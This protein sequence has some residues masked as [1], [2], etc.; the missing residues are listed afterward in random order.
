MLLEDWLV[1][2]VGSLL[3]GLHIAGLHR[4]T[5]NTWF[6]GKGLGLFCVILGLS[7]LAA[8]LRAWRSRKWGLWPLVGAPLTLA[9]HWL[10]FVVLL[11]GYENI[12][13]LVGSLRHVLYDEAL[14]RIDLALFPQHPTLWLESFVTPRRTAWFSFFYLSLYLYPLISGGLLYLGGR[15]TEFRH[16]M[17]TFTLVGL[18]GYLGY[19]C[20]PVIGPRYYFERYY[21]VALASGQALPS[22][23]DLQAWLAAPWAAI[24]DR[25]SYDQAMGSGEARNCFP[26]LH[27]A[28]GLVVLIFAY[29]QLRWLFWIYLMPIALLIL[30]TLYLRFHYVVD[31]LAGAALAIA[32]SYAIPQLERT[33]ARR[34]ASTVPAASL[35]EPGSDSQSLV[36]ALPLSALWRWF[37][38]YVESRSHLWP[39]LFLI[40]V[41]A[42]IYIAC[43]PSGLTDAHRGE[44]GAELVAAAVTG[45]V[46]HPTGY[47]LY[48][49]LLRGLCLVY[50]RA[51]PIDVAHVAS[52]VFTLAAG[53]VLLQTLRD[54]LRGWLD[55]ASPWLVE[56]PA[57]SA[58]VS[59]C[60]LGTVW[61]QAVIAEVYA[62]S[63]LFVALVLWQ[64]TRLLLD[65]NRRVERAGW[66]ALTFGLGL[67]H[68]LTLLHLLPAAVL[69]LWLC[70]AWRWGALWRMS[71]AGLLGLLPYL[72]LLVSAG[73]QPALNWGNPDTLPRLFA[74]ISGQQYRFRLHADPHAVW[75]RIAGRCALV[76]DAG[77]VAMLVGLFGAA[78][79]L[80]W[81]LRDTRRES[82]ARLRWLIVAAVMV[83]GNLI[84]AG[85]YDIEDLR[86]YFIPT[87]LVFA[88]AMGLGLSA[89]AWA[90]HSQH[91]LS[92]RARPIVVT[93]AVVMAASVLLRNAKSADLH[94]RHALD[95]EVRRIIAEAPPH[96][97]IIGHGDG[98]MFGLWYERFVRSQRRDIDIVNRDLLA[99]DW[100]IQSRN[101]FTPQ[102]RWPGG[103]DFHD[104]KLNPVEA[105][106]AAT[107]RANYGTR[108][109]LALRDYDALTGC[110]R[111]QDYRLV[112]PTP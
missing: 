106:L 74:T 99:Q 13:G 83:A 64:I 52:A 86:S 39:Q 112:C 5:L 72:S 110:R 75:A 15:L 65:T 55:Q 12:L 51:D 56:I 43:L 92:R 27:T 18:I 4:F 42:P 95:I 111:A 7:F 59:F 70:G 26:S 81:T 3:L 107:V 61:N 77:Q 41:V 16:F 20:V 14:M 29:R 47:P 84:G 44:D 69:T 79:A 88:C 33:W 23:A 66:L 87:E 67:C 108:P 31:L 24:A 104:G 2:A 11:V 94:G 30:S 6:V 17:L 71:A 10:P 60:F 28:W 93:L 78:M 89:L 45:G 73:R 103:F 57:L 85:L 50:R 54:L 109:I 102:L 90:G 63:A 101:H 96:A 62:L 76:A 53:L 40:A 32:G 9:R 100:Y 37:A 35:N 25:I 46:A 49:L 19:L 22:S 68:H 1:L 21:H 105:M 48:L 36:A 97:L 8:L 98:L 80:Y 91:G 58:A 34:T 82:S 38:K